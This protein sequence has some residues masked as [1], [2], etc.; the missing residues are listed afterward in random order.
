MTEARHGKGERAT[1]GA[2]S[3]ISWWTTGG[4]VATSVAVGAGTIWAMRALGLGSSVPLAVGSASAWTLQAL[5]FGW[6]ARPLSRGEPVLRPWVGGMAVRFGGLAVLGVAGYWSA[7]PAVDM[8]LAYGI[9][10][11]LL[12]L[13]EAVWL[14]KRQPASGRGRG[15]IRDHE[16]SGPTRRRLR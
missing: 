3:G 8:L 11:F 14:W 13:L 2:G 5:A 6:V 10:L 4:Y 7:L 12:L 15:E 16:R 1:R 9:T